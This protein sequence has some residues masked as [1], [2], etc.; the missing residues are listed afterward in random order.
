[1]LVGLPD[2]AFASCAVFFADVFHAVSELLYLF[3]CLVALIGIEGCFLE[4]SC[5]LAFASLT[6]IIRT[7]DGVRFR[8]SIAQRV[9]RAMVG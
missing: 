1:M 9:A 6:F 4:V 2:E 8:G 7:I 3:G 5:F